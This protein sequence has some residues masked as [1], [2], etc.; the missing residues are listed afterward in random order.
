MDPDTAKIDTS[1]EHALSGNVDALL[2][3][4]DLLMM[5]GS[6]SAHMRSTLK[7]YLESI[8]AGDESGYRR[9]WEAM[10]MISVSP[11]YVIEK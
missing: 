10:W 9:V 8:P 4:L 6:M 3:R 2:D 11:E 5:S 1:A 7:T